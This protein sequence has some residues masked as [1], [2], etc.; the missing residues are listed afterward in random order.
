MNGRAD[1]RLDDGGCLAMCVLTLGSSLCSVGEGRTALALVMQVGVEY[2]ERWKR[3]LGTYCTQYNSG[4]GLYEWG[5]IYHRRPSLPSCFHQCTFCYVGCRTTRVGLAAVPLLVS[6][7][8]CS[9]WWNKA[10]FLWDVRD[11][12]DSLAGSGW[13]H[14]ERGKGA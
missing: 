8:G 4:L 10:V 7:V 14:G 2:S 9:S 13:G 11:G 5:Y 3:I 6:Y 1:L 12:C